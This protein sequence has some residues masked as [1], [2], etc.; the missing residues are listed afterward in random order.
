M[1]SRFRVSSVA[2]FWLL[3]ALFVLGLIAG[4]AEPE[5]TPVPA[6]SPVV[7][8]TPTP[9]PT[10]T[11][12]PSPSPAPTATPPPPTATPTET[13]IPKP[14]LHSQPLGN[15]LKVILYEDHSAP[16]VSV[17]L[18][19]RVGSRNERVEGRGMAHIMEHMMFEGTDRFSRDQRSELIERAG[20]F[21]NAFTGDD[22]TAYF[23]VLPKEKL[24][25]EMEADR[26][27]SLV[28]SQEHFDSAREIVKEEYRV[29]VEND[30]FAQAFDRFR[31]LLFDGTPYAWSPGIV[32]D[33]DDISLADLKSFYQ[34]YY[35]P[36]NAVLVVAGDVT[37]LT[38]FAMAQT[39]F[40]GIPKAAP[41]PEV[42]VSL[43]EQTALQQE[44][45][46]MPVQLPAIVGGYH[47]PGVAHEDIPALEIAG[48]VLSAGESARMNRSLVREKRLA[49]FAAGFALT[50]RDLGVMAMFAFFT[51]DKDPQ[52][53]T[54][55]AVGEIERLKNEP[56]SEFE[57][58]KAKNQFTAG[59]IFNLDSPFGVANAIAEAEVVQGDYRLFEEALERY[60]DI[61]GADIQRVAQ[62][63]FTEDNLTIVTL[64]PGEAEKP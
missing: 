1:A 45:L 58:Q 13:P 64:S 24:A 30:P 52:E 32:E 50:F 60:R 25:L 20:G 10:D 35:T 14:T 6:P 8:A 28:F 59:Y 5:P 43:P 37:P 34:T 41:P 22:A 21:E 31:E 56:M 61:T 49:V 7:A 46:V 63:Y 62:R 47:V 36:N 26:M 44:T 42:L 53:V 18:W 57:L 29:R 3:G 9:Q 54:D 48:L 17:N 27:Q 40:D 2:S 12:E 11:P 4:C 38:L 55:A 19:Y 15:G 16:V 33:M 39:H 51:P 23:Q